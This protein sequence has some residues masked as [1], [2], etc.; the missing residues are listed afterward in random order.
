MKQLILLAA[1]FCLGT[2]T[3]R[4][5]SDSAKVARAFQ[6]LVDACKAKDKATAAKYILYTGNDKKKAFK[7]FVNF[8]TKEGKEIVDEWCRII[9]RDIME[10]E[11]YEI[12]GFEVEKESEGTWYI[13]K[14]SCTSD[15]EVTTMGVA[16][17]KVNGKFGLGDID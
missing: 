13:L 15:G 9:K 11:K 8:N 1:I 10:F 12:T 14:L 4:A 16:F 3:L 2:S 5:Q 17:L 6:Q 7:T